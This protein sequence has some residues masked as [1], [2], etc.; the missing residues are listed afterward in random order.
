MLSDKA[1][2]QTLAVMKIGLEAPVMT[3]NSVIFLLF[4]RQRLLLVEKC[5]HRS[6]STPVDHISSCSSPDNEV[7]AGHTRIEKDDAVYYKSN[8]FPESIKSTASLNLDM[9]VPFVSCCS[10]QT[11]H[12]HSNNSCT[13]Q[14]T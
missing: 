12:C 7:D 6:L 13:V 5:S 2:A 14:L 11:I 3:P 4:Q 9:D 10:V 1:H 8:S